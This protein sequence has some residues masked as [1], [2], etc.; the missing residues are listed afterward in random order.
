VKVLVLA[1]YKDWC[2]C[3]LS[4]HPYTLPPAYVLTR[5]H[6][7]RD[8]D[9]ANSRA[10]CGPNCREKIT[11][12]RNPVEIQI[13]EIF[14]REGRPWNFGGTHKIHRRFLTESTGSTWAGKEER[15]NVE[16]VHTHLF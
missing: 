9:L 1:T 4:L 6:K 10:D 16:T 11:V 2:T 13:D 8:E 5:C 12:Q 7:T 3:C 14:P 15:D